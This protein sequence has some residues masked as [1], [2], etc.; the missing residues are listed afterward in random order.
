MWKYMY[1]YHNRLHVL[2]LIGNFCNNGL[3]LYMWPIS[4]ILLSYYYASCGVHIDQYINAMMAAIHW[5][6]TTFHTKYMYSTET[7]HLHDRITH[8]RVCLSHFR[9]AYTTTGLKN[10]YSL[11]KYY[12]YLNKYLYQEGTISENFCQMLSQ[13]AFINHS[14]GSA[15]SE[16]YTTT[17]Y[18]I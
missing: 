9:L 17:M 14:S 2:E 13:P 4:V 6:W 8:S 1:W 15:E 7:L 18:I 12:W 5:Q 3:F 16:F 10:Q 11:R